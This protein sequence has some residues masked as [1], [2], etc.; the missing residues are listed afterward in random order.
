MAKAKNVPQLRAARTH[1]DLIVLKLLLL[2]KIYF[3][4]VVDA[5]VGNED[6]KLKE[7]SD[8]YE[9]DNP[10]HNQSPF[11][12]SLISLT[13]STFYF[14]KEQLCTKG[15]FFS[16]YSPICYIAISSCRISIRWQ[17]LE[18]LICTPAPINY[19]VQEVQK[20]D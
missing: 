10:V 14:F 12:P 16:K 7:S 1:I 15:L 6:E 19:D 3:G 5:R 2:L 13:I 4:T 20:P 11:L 9:S 8:N 18:Q 17:P